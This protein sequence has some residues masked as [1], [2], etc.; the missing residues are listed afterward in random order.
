MRYEQI[1]ESEYHP[2][3]CVCKECKPRTNNQ[4]R[5]DRTLKWRGMRRAKMESLP[6]FIREY[7]LEIAIDPIVDELSVPDEVVET[8]E[9]CR[10]PNAHFRGDYMEIHLWAKIHGTSKSQI[11]KWRKAN[12]NNK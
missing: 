6:E 10:D 9:H 2:D 3:S 1:G 8:L 11:N 5:A 7:R 12:E 4:L